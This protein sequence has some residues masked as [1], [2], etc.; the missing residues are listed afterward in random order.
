[1]VNP[2]YVGRVLTLL[3]GYT[4]AQYG[5][6]TYCWYVLLLQLLRALIGT[7]LIAMYAKNGIHHVAPQLFK[8]CTRPQK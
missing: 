5:L 2:T 7:V 6:L 4:E 8:F 1:M 3:T